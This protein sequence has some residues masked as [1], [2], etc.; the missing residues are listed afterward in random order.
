[1]GSDRPDG[2]SD[3]T[4]THFSVVSLDLAEPADG[5]V[6]AFADLVEFKVDFVARLRHIWLQR[7]VI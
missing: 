1:L 7:G 5:C 4:L 2:Q 6:E 3:G